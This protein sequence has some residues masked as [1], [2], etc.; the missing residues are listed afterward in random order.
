MLPAFAGLAFLFAMLDHL[1][2][3]LCLRSPVPGWE[4][5]EANPLAAWLFG[6]VGLVEGLALD[7]AVT[8]FAVLLVARTQ[9]FPQ[10]AKLG[11]L[12]MLIATSAFAVA[13]NFDVIQ[14][15][16]LLGNAGA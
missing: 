3:W 14:Q 15:I 1:T 5:R 10:A 6:H 4:I 12:G 2:T 7:S 8:V 16:G 9:R 13:N 11:L